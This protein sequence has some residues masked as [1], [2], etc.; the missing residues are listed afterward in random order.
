MSDNSIATLDGALIADYPLREL[1]LNGNPI[2]S[3]VALEPLSTL[4]KL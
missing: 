1:Q 4:Q 3:L 2:P